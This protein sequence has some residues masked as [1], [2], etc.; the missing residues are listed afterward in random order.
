MRKAINKI[1]MVLNIVLLSGILSCKK[2]L[3][4]PLPNDQVANETVFSAKATIDAV[5]TGMYSAFCEGHLTINVRALA[6]IADEAEGNFSDDQ[7]MLQTG[8]FSSSNT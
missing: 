7:L 2:Y 1:I 4:V 5:I 3:D 8:S 6:N